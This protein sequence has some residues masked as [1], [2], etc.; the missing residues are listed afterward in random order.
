MTIDTQEETIIELQEKVLNLKKR[1]RSV[2]QSRSWQSTKS[3]TSIKNYTWRE[4]F[5]LF[6]NDH[7]KSFK[8]LNSSVFID[9]DE[10]TWDSW[11]VK[12][13]DKLQTNVNHFDNE[14]ICI[15]Y[16]I[17]RLENDAAEHIFTWRWHDA[18]HSYISINELFEH[19]KEI[20]NEL[21]RNR[22]CHREYNAL[23]QADKSFNVF[24]FDFMKLFNYLNYDNCILMNDLQNK[25]NNR[26]QNALSVCS[27]NFTSLIR[28]RIFLQSVNNKQRVNY[29]LRSKH[30][31]VIVT[32]IIKVMIVSDKRTATSLSVTTSIIDYIKSIIFFTSESARSFIICYTCKIS[33]HLLKNCS[34]NKINTS[35]S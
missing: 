23:R 20:Y 11:R 19:L 26:L 28:L 17:S 15:V 35:A 1:Q 5:T 9:E 34:Q 32:V 31:T 27:K 33:S 30:H 24:Y 10:S 6:N 14:N 29:Q 25:I 12:M 7:H 22:K 16:V 18:L 2:N 21:N 3:W 8:F 13:N 4:S